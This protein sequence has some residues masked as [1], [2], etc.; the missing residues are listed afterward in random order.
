MTQTELAKSTVHTRNFRERMRMAD[1][2]ERRKE[3]RPA[4]TSDPDIAVYREAK[5]A[6][7]KREQDALDA[8][9][10]IFDRVSAD[11]ARKRMQR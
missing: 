10:V 5:M 9:R 7:A 4:Y 2:T 3:L 11:L 1:A 6:R 8:A